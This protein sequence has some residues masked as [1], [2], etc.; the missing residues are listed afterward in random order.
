MSKHI[1]TVHATEP[2]IKGPCTY[3]KKMILPENM[4]KHR[5]THTAAERQKILKHSYYAETLDLADKLIAS[6]KRLKSY[7]EKPGYTPSKAL[8]ESER[9]AKANLSVYKEKHMLL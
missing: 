2:K 4:T 5:N 9:L 1:K 3:C 8:I 6:K 7:E